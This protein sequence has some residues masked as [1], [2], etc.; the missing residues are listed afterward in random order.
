[1]VIYPVFDTYHLFSSILS[2]QKSPKYGSIKECVLDILS[3]PFQVLLS[4]P[5]CFLKNRNMDK[6]EEEPLA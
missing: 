4:L 2:F 3:E 5:D 6:P 1:M